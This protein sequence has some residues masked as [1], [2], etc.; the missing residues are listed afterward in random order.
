M[1][2]AKY[3]ED[4]QKLRDHA[5]SLRDARLDNRA[6]TSSPEKAIRE[7][8]RVQDALARWSEELVARLDEIL[9]QATDPEINRQILI[10]NQDTEIA[11]LH[12]HIRALTEELAGKATQLVDLVAALGESRVEAEKLKKSLAL[13][14]ESF[15]AITIEKDGLNQ[16]LSKYEKEAVKREERR[17]EAGDFLG[18]M[19]KDG[20]RPIRR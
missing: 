4:I 10:D 1:G 12:A 13:A 7:L 17:K 15:L 14:E 2:W 8:Q 11:Q 16:E 20:A 9:D 19:A 5:A 3:F 6:A 18:L